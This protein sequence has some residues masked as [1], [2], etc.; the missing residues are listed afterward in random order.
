[1]SCSHLSS[2]RYCIKFGVMVIPQTVLPYLTE[3]GKA[4]FNQYEPSLTPDIRDMQSL[5]EQ[6]KLSPDYA[7][8]I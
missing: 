7:C 8:G 5:E 3:T 4:A 1:M 2:S 6:R